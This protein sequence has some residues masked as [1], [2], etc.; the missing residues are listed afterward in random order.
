MIVKAALSF[1]L[2]YCK[3]WCSMTK[4]EK[5]LTWKA[6]C[7]VS[8]LILIGL[9][10][11][12]TWLKPHNNLE[13]ET[14]SLLRNLPTSIQYSQLT[15]K[16]NNPRQ[17]D[18]GTLQINK[19]TPL[20]HSLRG[21]QVDGDIII[22]ENQQ[23]VVTLGLRRLFDY[24]LSAQGEESL[25]QI[26]QRVIDYI[27]THTP[28]PAAGQA[29]AIYKKYLT[30]LEQVEVVQH[31][32]TDLRASNTLSTLPPNTMTF[33]EEQQ[34]VEKL[35]Q[36]LFDPSTIQAFFEQDDALNHY[37]LTVMKAMQDPNLTEA[38]KNNVQ[39]IARQQYIMRIG[40][41][42]TQ[43]NLRNQDSIGALLV[44]T[45]R[46]KQQGASE[47]ELNNMR[48]HY[49]NEDIVQKLS[50][51]DRE[52]ADFLRRIEE[53][54]IQRD[55]IIL[56]QGNSSQAQAAVERLQQQLFNDKERLR[57]SVYTK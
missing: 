28:Q 21:T 5:W 49:V 33:L 46:L 41:P 42:K 44:E 57:L 36:R 18:F 20:P 47:I 31:Q 40:D 32:S 16:A 53:Y 24:F 11:L 54:K 39:H 9:I 48:R 8:V 30:Y 6:I 2:K 19:E 13:S 26:N 25:E 45:E 56:A 7:I 55:R 12:I 37:T 14:H 43:E 23:L 17:I 35:R 1:T 3:G 38:Q 52:Q 29:T 27:N 34:A 15:N 10:R 22:N 50:Q 51:L 4:K